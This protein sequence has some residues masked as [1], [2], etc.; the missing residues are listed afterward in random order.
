M[1][2]QEEM[3]WEMEYKEELLLAHGSRFLLTQYKSILF[4]NFVIHVGPDRIEYITIH[5][6][7]MRN[8]LV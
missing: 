1:I 2:C 5:H 4:F 6:V 8:T 3:K 7:V